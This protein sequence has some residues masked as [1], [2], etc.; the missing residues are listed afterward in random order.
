MTRSTGWLAVPVIVIVIGLGC[1][2]PEPANP[3]RERAAEARDF[4]EN[5][6][7]REQR[8]ETRRDDE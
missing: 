5:L 1:D 8:R 3:F 4:Y 2:Q 6:R 7:T